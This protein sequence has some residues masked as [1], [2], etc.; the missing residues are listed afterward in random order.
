M[1]TNNNLK[2]RKIGCLV[3]CTEESVLSDSWYSEHQIWMDKIVVVSNSP[4]PENAEVAKRQGAAFSVLPGF[5]LDDALSLFENED[6]V[7]IVEADSEMPQSF[8]TMIKEFIWNPGVLYRANVSSSKS[9]KTALFQFFSLNANFLRELRTGN[10]TFFSSDL[11]VGN[12]LFGHWPRNKQYLL[13][14]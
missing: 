4:S 11:V 3:L 14:S 1:P 13:D 8:R 9:Q 12:P 7:L 6:W 2:P 10:W 5:S